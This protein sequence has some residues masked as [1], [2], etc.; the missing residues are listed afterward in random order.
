MAPRNDIRSVLAEIV[1][2]QAATGP[3]PNAGQNQLMVN[4]IISPNTKAYS[5]DPVVQQDIRG[6]SVVNRIF[7]VLSRPLYGVMNPLKETLE[8]VDKTNPQNL[9]DI[10]REF[11]RDPRENFRAMLEGWQGK[12]KTTGADVLEATGEPPGFKRAALGFGLDVLGDPLTYVGLGSAR[13]LGSGTARSIEALR[14]VEEGSGQVA[15][16]LTEEISRRAATEVSNIS[17]SVPTGRPPAPAIPSRGQAQEP[18]RVFQAGPGPG[19]PDFTRKA[20]G[21]GPT[22]RIPENLVPLDSM[23]ISTIKQSIDK[24]LPIDQA[25]MRPLLPVEKDILERGIQ[26]GKS[27]RELERDLAAATGKEPAKVFGAGPPVAKQLTQQDLDKIGDLERQRNTLIARAEA[28]EARNAPVAEINAVEKEIRRI[29]GEVETI[30]RTPETPTVTSV[31]PEAPIGTPTPKPPE[32]IRDLIEQVSG[33]G[34]NWR[35]LAERQLR[36]IPAGVDRITAL[37]FLE[38]QKLATRSPVYKNMIDTQIKKLR[39]GITP[40]NLVETARANPPAFPQLNLTA[41]RQTSAKQLAQAFMKAND[42]EEINHVGQTNLFNRL[43]NWAKRNVPAKAVNSTT[44]NMLRVAEDELL[45]AGRKLV[46][47]EGLPV[48]LSDVATLAGGSRAFGTKIV[49]DFRKAKPVQA[50]ETAKAHAL[51]DNARD[52]IDPIVKTAGKLADDTAGMP[53]SRTVQ[54]GND[55]SVALTKIAKDAGLSSREANTAK[56]FIE[57]F[58]APSRDSLHGEIMQEARNLIRQSMTGKTDPHMLGRINKEVYDALNANPKML[59]NSLMQTKVVEGIMTR[60][61]TWWNAKDLRPFAREYIDTARNVAAAFERAMTPIIRST[62][63]SQRESAWLVAQGKRSPANPQE[64]ELAQQ[65]Q[66]MTEKLLGAH[67]LTSAESVLIRSGT[68]MNDMN[69]LLPKRFQF[70]DTKSMD[71]LGREYNY[72][73]GNWMHSWKEWEAKEPTEALYQLTRALQ[74]ATRKNA[75]LDDAASRWGVPVKGGEFRHQVDV[76]RLRGFYFPREIAEQLNIVWNRLE[77]DKFKHGGS[78]WQLTD[79]IQ[80]MWK[81]GVTIYSP[82]H[83]IR[84]LNGDI[85]LAALDGVTSVVPYRKSMQVLHSQR[86]RYKD[87]ESVFNIMD[88]DLKQL[89]LQAHPGKTLVTTKAGHKLTSEQIYQA[90]ESQ[91]F[92]LRAAAL[93]DLLGESSSTFG[94][95]FSPFGGRVHQTAAKASEMRDHYVRMA[96]FID[97]LTKSRQKNLRDAIDEAGRRV[98]KF[99][100]DGSDL[101]GFEQS[102]LRRAIPFYSWIRKST[103]LLLEGLAMRP[104]ISVAFPKAMANLQEITGVESEGPGNPFPVDQMFP[105]WIKEKGIGPVFGPDH[106]LA[107]IG[108]QQTWRGDTP[109]YTIINPTN[110]LTDMLGELGRPRQTALSNITPFARIPMELATE[111]TSLGIPLS[112]VEGGTPGYLAQQ[113][114]AVGIGARI[115]GQTR[116]EEPYHPEQLIN[117]LLTGGLVT[118]T[119]P[120]KS[121]A[122]F[123]IRE[124][125]QEMGRKEREKRK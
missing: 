64:A 87:I 29:G 44:Y 8:E 26:T 27:S 13:S 48:R 30:K 116:P 38:A 110:P 63:P 52:I 45:A 22:P 81:T 47:A 62:K 111:Q 73:D 19:T 86:G 123:E 24:G 49:D 94:P 85:F 93:E 92:L 31:T 36:D 102:V 120:Y 77:T 68:T 107:G 66:F 14:G 113:V 37:T 43:Q 69:K 90:A 83:H 82:S 10:A 115:T 51:S 39:E 67:D 34:L 112:E 101:T 99:H 60:F 5:S 28:L 50:V 9:G 35:R 56:K 104:H 11:P 117:W 89:A 25:A 3:L 70:R 59:G 124:A 23:A 78:F 80:R 46:D 21:P 41:K 91:G 75:M 12:A 106:P 114:P 18:S 100:P 125:L 15:R 7:D 33:A 65:F 2:R 32:N 53:P 119:G 108:R 54:L 4:A 17:P 79:K 95:K 72:R 58:F 84:N 6:P 103:P 98:K 55:L 61:A 105:D 40:A 16:N 20:I 109:G 1:R 118:G 74:L 121:Q 57:D 122:Q 88:P 97:S 42:F 76:D 96:H 71:K